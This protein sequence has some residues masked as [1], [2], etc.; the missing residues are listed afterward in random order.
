MNAC[1]FAADHQEERMEL[2]AFRPKT[3]AETDGEARQSGFRDGS[4]MLGA[5]F[6]YHSQK[7]IEHMWKEKPYNLYSV[8]ISYD[9]ISYNCTT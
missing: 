9:D 2:L 7:Y 3:M 5:G 1:E 4:N 6:L 8:F